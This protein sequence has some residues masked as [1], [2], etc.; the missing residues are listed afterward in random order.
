MDGFTKEVIVT[1]V[2]NKAIMEDMVMIMK[3]GDDD[4]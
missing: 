3:D 2:V 1:T 4:D